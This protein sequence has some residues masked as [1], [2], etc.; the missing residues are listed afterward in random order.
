MEKLKL[1]PLII[2]AKEILVRLGWEKAGDYYLLG[3]NPRTHY[4][5]LAALEA[6][7]ERLADLIRGIKGGANQEAA[8]AAD[9]QC[10]KDLEQKIA[11][12]EMERN[13]PLHRLQRQFE[14]ALRALAKRFKGLP[15]TLLPLEKDLPFDENNPTRIS[16]IPI[17]KEARKG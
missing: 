5:L 14:T 3:G 6:E 9:E 4:P 10:R 12:I 7:K 11:L 2:E 15:P 17:P 16:D 13:H 8:S 1:N